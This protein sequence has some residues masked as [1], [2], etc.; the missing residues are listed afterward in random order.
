MDV[1]LEL[2]KAGM[3]NHEDLFAER[4]H[5]NSKTNETR[6][7]GSGSLRFNF[8]ISISAWGGI[9]YDCFA[10]LA[11]WLNMVLLS[12]FLACCLLL[13]SN[14]VLQWFPRMDEY[15]STLSNIDL[16]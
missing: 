15:L 1:K 5:Q 12:V 13:L 4:N 14:R 2:K 10:V 6:S 3:G 9:G 8:I 7:L 11:L 16:V